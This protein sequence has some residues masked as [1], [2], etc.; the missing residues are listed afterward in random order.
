MTVA[1][2]SETHQPR[3][4]PPAN[5]IHEFVFR[6]RSP[7]EVRTAKFPIAFLL[8]AMA[9]A[10]S[11]HGLVIQ[12]W[13]YCHTVPLLGFCLLVASLVAL[14]GFA[15][16]FWLRRRIR[17]RNLRMNIAFGCLV[18]AGAFSVFSL[19]HLAMDTITQLVAWL[20]NQQLSDHHASNFSRAQLIIWIGLEVLSL[21]WFVSA[22]HRLP[23][24][25][26]KQTSLRLDEKDSRY[27]IVPQASEKT[28]HL[29]SP[30]PEWIY[31]A[32]IQHLVLQLSLPRTPMAITAD[33]LLAFGA[34]REVILPGRN[35]Q[36]DIKLLNHFRPPNNCNWQ[37]ILRA[38][39]PHVSSLK[40]VWIIGSSGD[41]DGKSDSEIVDVVPPLSAGSFVFRE[42][43]AKLIAPY[44]SNAGAAIYL[45]A[46]HNQEP[47]MFQN[48]DHVRQ[49]ITS[50]IEEIE[51]TFP[52]GGH[53]HNILVDTTGGQK[54]ISIAGASITYKRR[55]MFQYVDTDTTQGCPVHLYDVE[56]ES[57]P[58]TGL[59]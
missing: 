40:S 57:K 23:E 47:L 46:P 5:S 7:N 59:S 27:Y 43:A 20:T 38:I 25:T 26:L 49:A 19:C 51:H 41:W 48:Y 18:L 50:A 3:P 8:A 21:L 37:Q 35:I 56:F 45:C 4:G 11:T 29:L 44:L 30:D 9:L 15:R 55:V 2:V 1:S 14:L 58:E 6:L 52:H 10:I 31:A 34:N 42:L 39:A 24:L 13:E 53:Q 36:E 54:L 32:Q 17:H 16:F 33:G 22:E 12:I 28:E